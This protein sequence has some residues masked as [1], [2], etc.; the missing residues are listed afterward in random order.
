MAQANESVQEAEKM[1]REYQMTQEQLRATSM[2]L[3]QMQIQKAELSKAKEEITGSTG[4]VYIT[5]GGVIVET[6][7]E[8]ALDEINSRSEMTDVRITSLT[9]QYTELKTK[10]KQ[11]GEK[12]TQMYKQN[13]GTS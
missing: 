12:L 11:L 13:K 5:V 3:D 2:Q 8:K 6:T 9:K 10:D 4:K 7:K 1:I